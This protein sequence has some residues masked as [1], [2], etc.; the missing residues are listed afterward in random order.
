MIQVTNV[1]SLVLAED[2]LASVSRASSAVLAAAAFSVVEDASVA[3]AAVDA[4]VVVDV[5]VA[6]VADAATVNHINELV[7]LRN[8]PCMSECRGSFISSRQIT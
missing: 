8:C 6:E 5:A 4:S 7:K 2:A 3:A 1:F